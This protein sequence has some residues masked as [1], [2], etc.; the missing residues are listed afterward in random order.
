MWEAADVQWRWRRFGLA[1]TSTGGG[2]R[3]RTAVEGFAGPCLDHSA[4]PPGGT[5]TRASLYRLKVSPVRRHLR[6]AHGLTSVM[7][8]QAGAPRQ[9]KQFS[10]PKLTHLPLTRII[11]LALAGRKGHEVA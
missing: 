6:P 2:E 9:A 8:T 10:A 1:G 4:T 7:T 5:A 11:G 3:K